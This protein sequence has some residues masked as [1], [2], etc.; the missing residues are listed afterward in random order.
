MGPAWDK[1]KAKVGPD[2]FIR[3]MGIVEK[4]SK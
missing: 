4:N 2:N 3:F 1:V